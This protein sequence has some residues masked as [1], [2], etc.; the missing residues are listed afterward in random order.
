MIKEDT[1]TILYNEIVKNPE[2]DALKAVYADWLDEVTSADTPWLAD[3]AK[4]IR[5]QLGIVPTEES[6]TDILQRMHGGITNRR[7]WLETHYETN[8]LIDAQWRNGFVQD[9]MCDFDFWLREGYAMC[10]LH[11]IASLWLFSP[12]PFSLPV[13]LFHDA[14]SR[15][16]WLDPRRFR[17]FPLMTSSKFL[18]LQK[19]RHSTQV[20]NLELF[21]LNSQVRAVVFSR[22]LEETRRSPVALQNRRTA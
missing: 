16:L 12:G 1:G 10:A 4:L 6:V 18:D 13:T 17:T 20:R 11:P 9:I 5:K 22:I 21:H 3:R 19:E 7:R 2:D 15:T 14:K 8:V